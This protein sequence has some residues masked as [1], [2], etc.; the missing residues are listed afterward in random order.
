VQGCDIS[1][2]ANAIVILGGSGVVVSSNN[3]RLLGEGGVVVR[4]TSVSR[5]HRIENNVI[6]SIG[7]DVPVWSAAINIGFD[8]SLDARISNV[9]VVGNFIQDTPHAA[10]LSS[11]VN[12]VYEFNEINDF[13]KVSNDS[14][15]FYRFVCSRLLKRN[16][17]QLFTSFIGGWKFYLLLIFSGNF[18]G[19]RGNTFRSNL[20][21]NSPLGDGIF[22]DFQ[23]TADIIVGNVAVNLFRCFKVRFLSE[24][25]HCV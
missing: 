4:G 11:S 16:M 14:G 7:L 24:N 10:I 2:V 1:C 9:A 23:S 3:M 20:M 22:L 15:A 18:V 12:S 17:C 6:F 19:A 25:G 8:V 13:C 5:N 21:Y